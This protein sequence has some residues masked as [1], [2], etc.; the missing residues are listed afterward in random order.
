[1]DLKRLR[2]FAEVARLENFSKASRQLYVAQPALSRQIRLLEGE[3]GFELFQRHVRGAKLTPEGRTLFDRVEPLLR[4]F[5]QLQHEVRGAGPRGPVI[6][7]FSPSLVRVLGAPFAGAL[8]KKF[9]NVQL[10]LVEVF[11]PTLL[12]L[13]RDG[14]MDVAIANGPV[15]MDGLQLDPIC[16]EQLCLIGPA[17]DARLSRKKISLPALSGFP[18]VLAGLAKAGIR[19]VLETEAAKRRIALNCVVEVDTVQAARAMVLEGLG[20]TVHLASLIEDDLVAG[21]LA[22]VPIDA[23]ELRRMVVWSQRRRLSQAAREVTQ[24]LRQTII[25]LIESGRWRGARLLTR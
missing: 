17:G 11:S 6:V 3:L 15:P 2:Y 23:L 13:L 25:D 14:R 4:E 10:K 24:L 12:D 18:L 9:P 20:F 16:A 8:V 1:M 5:E 22:A 7:G 19:D 21:R